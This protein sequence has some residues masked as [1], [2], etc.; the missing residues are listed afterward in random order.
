Y[1]SAP[2]SCTKRVVIMLHEKEGAFKFVEIYLERSPISYAPISNDDDGYV[3]CES[4]VICRYIEE[5][6]ADKG[7]QK[8]ILNHSIEAKGLFEQAVS[9]ETANFDPHASLAAYEVLTKPAYTDTEALASCISELKAMLD[10]YEGILSKQAYLAGDEVTL[11]DLF[12]VASGVRLQLAAI[13]A[14]ETRPNVC[15]W[16]NSLTDRSSWK[17]I[18][19][20]MHHL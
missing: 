17:A 2:S 18:Q 20:G 12:H 3:L 19:T 5:K 4:R 15:R 7:I 14:I 1:G 6:Y 11:A 16:F 13:G 9:V 10:V 8:L